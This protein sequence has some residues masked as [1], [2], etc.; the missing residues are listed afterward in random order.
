MVHGRR[1]TRSY[2]KYTKV[3]EN[4]QAVSGLVSSHTVA[5]PKERKSLF[6][7]CFIF[8]AYPLQLY[9]ILQEK[10]KWHQHEWNQLETRL[11]T[12]SRS[13]NN[14]NKQ[15]QHCSADYPLTITAKRLTNAF[16]FKCSVTVTA[17]LLVVE[18]YLLCL[19]STAAAAVLLRLT[20]PCYTTFGG[21]LLFVH[22][23]TYYWSLL[24]QV[25]FILYNE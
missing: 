10:C 19:S 4:T 23:S 20:L 2:D 21:W 18:T 24:E 16:M 3:K 12:N 22:I 6:F 7:C 11:E 25:L 8:L 13:S 9:F 1:N 17:C 15:N 14:N 5:R